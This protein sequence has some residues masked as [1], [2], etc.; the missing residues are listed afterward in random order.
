MHHSGKLERQTPDCTAHRSDTWW[1]QA[2]L[3]QP[4]CVEHGQPNLS[5]SS[6]C[7]DCL[8]LSY[9]LTDCFNH[10]AEEAL[11][12]HSGTPLH[13]HQHTQMGSVD[14][15]QQHTSAIQMIQHICATT[16]SPLKSTPQR[17]SAMRSGTT[18]A[19]WW[20]FLIWLVR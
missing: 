1:L 7:T 5:L 4:C 8:H 3:L 18:S 9:T 17:P 12:H 10:L 6:A 11:A 2:F 13:H 14:T 15:P 20:T 19:D 16:L